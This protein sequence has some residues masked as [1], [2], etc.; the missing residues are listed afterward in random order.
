MMIVDMMRIGLWFI[1]AFATMIVIN[2]MVTEIVNVVDI[3][4][5]REENKDDKD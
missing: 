1:Q 2:L 4:G 3:I 5:G